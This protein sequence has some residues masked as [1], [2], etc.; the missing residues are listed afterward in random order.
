MLLMT[1]SS[2][3]LPDLCFSCELLFAEEQP[4]YSS[5]A[6]P[7]GNDSNGNSEMLIVLIGSLMPRVTPAT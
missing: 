3:L 7:E 5:Q 1:P 2:C 6:V 4:L